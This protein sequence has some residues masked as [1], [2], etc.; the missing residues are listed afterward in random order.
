MLHPIISI[1]RRQCEDWFL[2]GPLNFSLG[3][4][5]TPLLL[6]GSQTGEPSP[7]L[8]RLRLLTPSAEGVRLFLRGRFSSFKEGGLHC[9]QSLPSISFPL[10]PLSAPTSSLSWSSS[11]GRGP[12]SSPASWPVPPC[13]KATQT[14]GHCELPSAPLLPL[15]AG[16]PG[17]SPS[18][19]NTWAPPSLQHPSARCLTATLKMPAGPD[20]G[21]YIL[22]RVTVKVTGGFLRL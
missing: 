18:P 12:Q 15:L 5:E 11:P 9:P 10:L 1:R 20:L 22:Y 13:K 16:A 2:Q 14:G 7:T 17:C 3:D 19:P 6:Q 8:P 4:P 21:H